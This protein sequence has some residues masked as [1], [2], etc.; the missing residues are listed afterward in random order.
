MV[1]LI[2]MGALLATTAVLF[3]GALIMRARTLEVASRDTVVAATSAPVTL[4]PVSPES[5]RIVATANPFRLD[6]RPA[7]A[8][9]DPVGSVEATPPP[10]RPTLAV[11]GI[12]WSSRPVAILEGLPGIDGPRLV[13]AG[14]RFGPLEVRSIHPSRVVVR[15]PDT[16]WTLAVREPWR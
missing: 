15:G 11:S 2:E 5:L 10:V 4:T 7:S 9:Y 8:H 16:T 6:R 1:S 14:D 12:L 13:Q 3:T